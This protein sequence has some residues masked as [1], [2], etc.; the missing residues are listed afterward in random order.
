MNKICFILKGASGSGKTTLAETLTTNGGVICCADDGF[1][2]DNTYV[3]DG[4]KLGYCHNLCEEK[5]IGALDMQVSPI[6][7]ANT[8]TTPKE[9]ALYDKLAKENGY[10][11]FHLIVENRHGGKDIHNVPP[12]TLQKQEHNIRS[13]LKLI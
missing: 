8:N 7:V 4:R 6:V 9:W 5:F 3:F 10:T 13:N 2:V 11:V 1:V 12:K